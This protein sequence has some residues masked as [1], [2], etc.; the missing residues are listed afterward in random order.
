MSFDA[1]F[2]HRWNDVIARGIRRITVNGTPLE[3][4][5]VDTR[6][7]SDSILT[8]I[9]TGVANS[10]LVFCDLTTI[11]QL[12]GKAAR[13]GNV[14]YEIG[15]AQ[16]VRLPEEVLLFRSDNDPLLFDTSTVRVNHYDP[17]SFPEQARD[18]VASAILGAFKEVDLRNHLAVRKAV[19]LLDY[20]SWFLL[21]SSMKTGSASHPKMKTMGDVLS[22]TRWASAISNLLALGALGTDFGSIT[23]ESLLGADRNRPAEDLLTYRVTEFGQ[24]MFR[25]SMSRMGLL[26]PEMQVAVQ[27]WIDNDPAEE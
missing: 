11:G 10:R 15:L 24:A 25:E 9:L 20:P 6:T 8:E 16:A 12:D 22:N 4:I 1:E 19:E 23:P 17:D 21:C 27:A 3:P 14:M 7:I 18:K 5:R 13:N 2:D 26:T